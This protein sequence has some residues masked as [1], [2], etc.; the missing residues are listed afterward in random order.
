[1]ESPSWGG[2]RLGQE[3]GATGP[4]SIIES[5]SLERSKDGSS[6]ESKSD[7]DG[8]KGVRRSLRKRLPLPSGGKGSIPED[9]S[10]L[11]GI[12]GGTESSHNPPWDTPGAFA[13]V[14]EDP[15]ASMEAILESKSGQDTAAWSPSQSTHLS[16]H[17]HG[18]LA[19]ARQPPGLPQPLKFRQYFFL[20]H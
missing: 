5:S 13:G 16:A 1:M 8:G 15:Q 10:E 9:T 14:G 3:G 12:C 19:E 18:L 7:T 20:L 17:W 11:V 2:V 4:L 6:S